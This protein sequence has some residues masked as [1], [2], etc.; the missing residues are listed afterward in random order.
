MILSKKYYFNLPNIQNAMNSIKVGNAEKFM[1]TNKKIA[2][3]FVFES[4][5]V[6]PNFS[7]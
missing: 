3:L 2:T 7:K 5:R 6:E 1:G 4:K